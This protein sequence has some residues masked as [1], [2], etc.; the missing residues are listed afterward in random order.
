[1]ELFVFQFY[2]IVLSGVKGLNNFYSC[3]SLKRFLR[4]C[5]PEIMWDLLFLE[6]PEW[7]ITPY[8][9]CAQL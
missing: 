5:W 4:L 7:M 6:T 9:D 3:F 1:M 8:R 2:N